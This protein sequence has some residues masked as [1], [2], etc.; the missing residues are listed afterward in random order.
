MVSTPELR[1]DGAADDRQLDPQRLVTRLEW[2]VLRRLDGRLQGDYRSLLRGNGI[3][4]RDLREYQPG[5]DLRQIDWNVTARTD[6]PHVRQYAQDRDVTGWLLL[7][8]SASM[9]VGTSGRSKQRVLA[10]LSVLLAQV[11]VRG[12]NRVGAVL[13]GDR[14][15][16]VVAPRH[17]RIQALRVARE[18][19]AEPPT[20]ATPTEL[21]ELLRATIG[22][23]RQ[24][25]LV[26]VVSDFVSRPG[27][28]GPLGLLAQRHDVL[29]IHLT[30]DLDHRLPDAGLI[31]VSDP[32]TGQHVLVDTSDPVF[33]QRL[34]ALAAAQRDELHAAVARAGIVLHEIDTGEDLGEAVLRIA[35]R[36]AALR[37]LAR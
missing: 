11:L 6:V 26:V 3:D 7:D 36:R 37:G 5:D 23:A 8:R 12:G 18:V 35:R 21:A 22:L 13:Y 4:L 1:P 15:H 25:S 2:T 33:R 17:G 14:V 32:E 30:D 16:R 20:S 10:E 31:A 27:W 34:T 24:R 29:A 28:Q 9:N 19:L